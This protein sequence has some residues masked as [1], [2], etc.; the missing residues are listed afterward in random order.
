MKNKLA[1]ALGLALIAIPQFNTPAEAQLSNMM[2][3]GGGS[4]QGM[5]SMGPAVPSVG[6]ASPTNLA[7][8]LQYCVQNNYLGGASASSATSAKA[9][10]LSKFTGSSTAPSSDSGYS[11]GS[12]GL[13]DTGNGQTTSLGGSGL[14]AQ[15][16][17]KVC[18]MVLSHAQ[19]M[20]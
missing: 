20:L 19:S 10:L 16:T 17:Q 15:M 2:Q 6:S 11:A 14:K 8:V 1:A 7:G 12:N 18:G 4:M 3:G 5:M 9:S 13:L